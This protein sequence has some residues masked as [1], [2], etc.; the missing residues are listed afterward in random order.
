[1]CAVGRE[2]GSGVESEGVCSHE[3]ELVLVGNSDYKFVIK[4][5]VIININKNCE[6]IVNATVFISQRRPHLLHTHM[7]PPYTHTH[8]HTHTHTYTHTQTSLRKTRISA[9]LTWSQTEYSPS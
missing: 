9:G 5:S 2:R 8:T 7:V 4:Q 6:V 1:M 3:D